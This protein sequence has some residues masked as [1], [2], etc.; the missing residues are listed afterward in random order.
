MIRR[1]PPLGP[2]QGLRG[3]D[4]GG[5]HDRPLYANTGAV[6]DDSMTV[7][8]KGNDWKREEYTDK[9]GVQRIHLSRR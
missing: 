3:G 4:R 8:A 1:I 6:V 7:G 5:S 2:T 9:N